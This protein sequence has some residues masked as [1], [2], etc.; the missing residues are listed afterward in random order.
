[1]TEAEWLTSTDP[2]FM[3]KFL[4]GKISDRKF[5][6]FAVACCRRL[7]RVVTVDPKD[8]YAVDAAERFADRIATVAEM[9]AASRYVPE[10]PSARRTAAFACRD[11]I[12]LEAG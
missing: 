10:P 7:V 3:L 1:M 11:A 4:G 9:Q 12:G 6:L 5:R 8:E 2:Q